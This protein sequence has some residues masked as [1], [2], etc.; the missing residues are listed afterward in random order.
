[1]LH[2][3]YHH[4]AKVTGYGDT[5]WNAIAS[6]IGKDAAAKIRKD[7]TENYTLRWTD[8]LTRSIAP[9]QNQGEAPVRKFDTMYEQCGIETVSN[10]PAARRIVITI[11]RSQN[12][13]VLAHIQGDELVKTPEPA[14]VRDTR[15][16]V[17]RSLPAP[18]GK[19][20]LRIKRGSR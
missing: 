7:L 9:Q 4:D 10:D 5:V 12:H 3:I 6:A 19:P 8:W 1:M 15:R 18:V 16:R 20:K 14:P 11:Y 17:S 2:K 13:N